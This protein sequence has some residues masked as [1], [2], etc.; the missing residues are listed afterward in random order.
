MAMKY[1]PECKSWVNVYNEQTICPKCNSPE[2]P[3]RQLREA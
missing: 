2:W 1:C 3:N